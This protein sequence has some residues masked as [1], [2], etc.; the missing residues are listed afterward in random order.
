[1]ADGNIVSG[2]DLWALPS[3]D[4][5]LCDERKLRLLGVY[6]CGKKSVAV[7]RKAWALTLACFSA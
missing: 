7:S 4:V 1:M 2:F 6:F 5:G 3:F